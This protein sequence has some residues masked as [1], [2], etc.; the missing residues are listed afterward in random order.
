MTVEEYREKLRSNILA[1]CDDEPE[2]WLQAVREAKNVGTLAYL[3]AV[4]AADAP[5]VMYALV[6]AAV[7]EGMNWDELSDAP[8]HY[9]T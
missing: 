7:E 9:D 4:N 1:K 3:M 6:E 2:E 8:S 5:S